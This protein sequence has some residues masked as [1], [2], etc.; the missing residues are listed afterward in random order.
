MKPAPFESH[1]GIA[2]T[3]EQLETTSNI[4]TKISV[5]RSSIRKVVQ[6]TTVSFKDIANLL[7]AQIY[8]HNQA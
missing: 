5:G 7:N 1:E 8:K 3:S 2:T 6:T 4:T